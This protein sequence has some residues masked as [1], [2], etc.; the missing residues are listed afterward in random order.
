MRTPQIQ[1]LFLSKDTLIN[2]ILAVVIGI[3]TGFGAIGFRWLIETFK[4]LFF[5]EGQQALSFLGGYYVVIIPAIGGLLVGLLVY[6]AAREAKGH[7]VPEVMAAVAFKGGVIRP[8]VV[9][10]KSFASAI[11]IGSGGS[12]GREGPIVQIGSAIGSTIGQLSRI[13]SR[14][15]K[16]FVACGAAG[17]IAATFNAPIGGVLFALEVILGKFS[18]VHLILVIIS[19]LLSAVVSR[20][21]LGDVPAFIVPAY[22]LH[23][24]WELILYAGMG[25]ISGIFAVLY[26]RTLYKF[27][28]I[29]NAIRVIPEYLKPVLGGLL[30]GCIGYF[31][32]IFLGWVMS[33][34]SWP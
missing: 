26:I 12:V 6:Y 21:F 31:Y 34:L 20:V 16:A 17:G 8:R 14:R 3:A 5:T 19:V 1:E 24:P 28:D 32:P 7:G 13:D 11:C 4:H 18:G 29:F 33:P 30:V 27:E 22:P 15:L 23:S 2:L 25:V 10:V 9:L